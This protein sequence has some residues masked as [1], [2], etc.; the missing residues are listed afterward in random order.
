MAFPTGDAPDLEEWQM[1]YNGL[2]TGPGTPYDLVTADFLN[3]PNIRSGDT[4]RSRQGG[5]QQGLDLYDGRDTTITGNVKT[6]GTSAWHAARAL[7]VA[8]KRTSGESPFWVNVPGWGVIG[9]MAKVRKRNIPLNMEFYASGV[10]RVSMLLASSDQRLYGAQQTT[11]ITLTDG[12]E[13]IDNT[14]DEEMR[15]IFTI[16][17]GICTNPVFNRNFGLNFSIP[18]SNP[19]QGDGPTLTD[20]DDIIT[21][22]M[23]AH[24]AT[25]FDHSTGDISNI[26]NWVQP[27]AIWDSDLV[28]LAP[29][30]NSIGYGSDDESDT[31]A[32]LTV[33]WAPAFIP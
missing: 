8:Y 2:T 14:G 13:V 31:G 9:T 11:D 17:G 24:T 3:L 4:P 21:V 5:R 26:R 12:S 23:D 10:G 28:C 29:G 33:T 16:T 15:P 1:A 30:D 25:Y 18:I 7:G 6:D 22:D 27:G 32:V 20:A 19:N